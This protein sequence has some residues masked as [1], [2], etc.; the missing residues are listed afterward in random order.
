MI[1]FKYILKIQCIDLFLTR[2]IQPT[3]ISAHLTWASGIR[4]RLLVSVN[5]TPL[6]WAKSGGVQFTLTLTSSLQWMPLAQ[7]KW[8]LIRVSCIFLVKRRSIHWILRIYLKETTHAHQ[9]SFENEHELYRPSPNKTIWSQKGTLRP[10]CVNRS[11]C[12][13]MNGYLEESLK[14]Y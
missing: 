7:V 2:N 6:V 3:R 8:A 9:R 4:L 14:K 13:Q 11:F 10:L 5:C 12:I 1:S